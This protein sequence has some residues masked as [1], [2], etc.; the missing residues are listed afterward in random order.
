MTEHPG[1]GTMPAR[2]LDHR[3]LG[4]QQLA[5]RAGLDADEVRSVL[6]GRGPDAEPLRRLAPAPGFHAVDLFALAGAAVPEDMAPLDAA[7]AP[8]VKN[9]VTDTAR[10]PAAERRALLRLIRSLPQE[11]RRS[12]FTPNP[13][14]P[15]ADRPG[16]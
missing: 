9:T 12:G 15:L 14:L 3:E 13:P 8:W 10:L 1:F 2:L 6:S 4:A 5:D 11:E 7:A 16:P